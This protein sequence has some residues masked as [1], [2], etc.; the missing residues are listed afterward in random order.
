MNIIDS[1]L[2]ST[3]G[4]LSQSL[5]ITKYTTITSCNEPENET[6][7]VSQCPIHNS[8]N[9]KVSFPVPQRNS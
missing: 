5:E 7:R 9:N 6:Y 1:P 8:I 2:K 3:G 4:R